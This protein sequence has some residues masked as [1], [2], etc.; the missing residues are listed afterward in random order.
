MLAFGV[1]FRYF[2]PYTA[3]D[4]PVIGQF[5]PKESHHRGK[6]A[7]INAYIN[8]RIPGLWLFSYRK[9]EYARVT[10]ANG[11]GYQQ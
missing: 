6:A 11:F 8:F 7:D 9:S 10:T 1:E 4:S 3:D 5:L 2:T